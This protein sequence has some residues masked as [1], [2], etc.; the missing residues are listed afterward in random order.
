ML[1]MDYDDGFVA[2]LNGVEIGRSNLGIEGIRPDWNETA[3][4]SHEAVMYQGMNPDS[5]ELDMNI[6]RGAF[7]N[8]LNVL[9]IEVH[10]TSGFNLDLSAIAFLSFKLNNAFSMFGPPPAWFA[11]AQ[12]P[13]Y[14]HSEAKRIT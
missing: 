13:D 4:S 2:Y 12:V 5:F 8:G 6:V 7:V 9:A 14:F 1:H 3:T 11:A 10:N